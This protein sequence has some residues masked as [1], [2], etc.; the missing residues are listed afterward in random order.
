[1]EIV[2]E[3]GLARVGEAH[4]RTQSGRYL[5]DVPPR[6]AAKTEMKSVFHVPRYPSVVPKLWLRESINARYI[7]VFE[8]W[9]RFL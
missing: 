5:P 2:S 8:N 6:S 3:H 4:R 1:M 7:Y 9:G